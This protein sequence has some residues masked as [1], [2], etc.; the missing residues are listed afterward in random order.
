MR[1][2]G[3]MALSAGQVEASVSAVFND[4]VTSSKKAMR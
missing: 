1:R 3:V 2:A 4:V